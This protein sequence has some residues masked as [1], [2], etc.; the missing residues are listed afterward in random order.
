MGML[1]AA[2]FP[3]KRQ[4]AEEIVGWMVPA[5]VMLQ[6]RSGFAWGDTMCQRAKGPSD[7]CKI[8]AFRST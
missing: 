4:N 5:L 8:S 6:L 1:G 7:W 2:F 3:K